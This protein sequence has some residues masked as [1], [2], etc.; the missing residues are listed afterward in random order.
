MTRFKLWKDW[1]KHCTNNPVYKFLVLI[2]LMHSPSFDMHQKIMEK[3]K[4]YPTY[5]YSVQDN[6]PEKSKKTDTGPKINW[7]WYTVYLLMIVANAVMFYIH[8]FSTISWQYL[9]YV[10]M[11]IL[12]FVAGSNYRK[13]V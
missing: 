2:G 7:Y 8:D 3:L 10:W 1:N 5:E 9:A 4:Q 11:M 6:K 12:C 13:E